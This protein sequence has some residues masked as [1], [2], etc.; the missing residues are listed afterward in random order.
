MPTQ[1][2]SNLSITTRL[3]TL[4]APPSYT[5]EEGVWRNRLL[6]LAIW[7]LLPTSTIAG[8]VIASV[9]TR[10]TG[11]LVGASVS[12]T[13]AGVLILLMRKGQKRRASYIL[14]Y[15][16]CVVF[17]A[18]FYFFG[19]LQGPFLSYV[20]IIMIGSF[21]L[22]WQAAIFT[23]VIGVVSGLGMMLAEING[24]LPATQL[25]RTVVGDWIVA[26]LVFAV[27]AFVMGI[28]TRDVDHSL[29]SA[30]KELRER[31]QM[32]GEL[33][34]LAAIVKQTTETVII[35]DPDGEIVYVNPQ[36]ET[37][38]G[39]RAEEVIGKNPRL[40]KSGSH[41]AEFYSG[42]WDTIQAGK[43]WRGVIKN[44]R[45][46]GSLY[47]K[48]SDIFPVRGPDDELIYYADVS[49]D[50]TDRLRNNLALEQRV[51]ELTVL[52]AVA[53]AN[54]EAVNEDGLIE[55]ITQ[56][57]GETLYSDHFGVLLLV[58]NDSGLQP[59]PSYHGISE[60]D[61]STV[62][63]LDAGVAGHVAR[64]GQP[65]RVSDVTKEPLYFNVTPNMRSELCIP[66]RSG[67]RTIG[68][69]NAESAE[70][71]AFTEFDEQLMTTLAD[72]MATGIEKVRLFEESQQQTRELIAMN[73]LALET[74]SVLDMNLLLYRLYEEIQELIPAE[75]FLVTLFNETKQE[76][77]IAL[78]MEDNEIVEEMID[79]VLPMANGGLSG[80]V[81]KTQEPLLI[82]D[83]LHDTVPVPPKHGSRPARSWLGVP[84]AARGSIIGAISLQSF[85]PNFFSRNQ[86]RLVESLAAQVAIALDNAKLFEAEQ[87]RRRELQAMATI[88][89]ALREAE[90]RGEMLP[91][92]LQKVE[93]FSQA[94]GT[95]LWMLAPRNQ[96][97]LCELSSG[98]W[99]SCSGLRREVDKEFKTA[100]D[101]GVPLQ[102]ERNSQDWPEGQAELF[103]GLDAI[104]HIPLISEDQHLGILCVG[105][106][107]PFEEGEIRV[108]S[109]IA[110]ISSNAI[111][112]ASLHD[113]TEQ[114]LER[115]HSLRRIDQAINASLDLGLTLRILVEQVTSQL[116]T[117][118][119]SVSLLIPRTQT[120]ETAARLGFQSESQLSSHIRLGSGLA[121][122]AALER[123][124]I[125]VGNFEASMTDPE[126]ARMMENEGFQA[127]FAVPLLA[128]GRVKGVLEVFNRKPLD[129]DLEWI[130]F[131]ETLAG[132]AAIAVE[133]ANLVQNL[134]RTNLE[135]TLAYDTT[136]EGWAH[137]LELRDHETQGHAQRVTEL[138]LQLAREL[139][140]T[141]EAL[142]NIRR[143]TLLHD[144]GKMGIP[145]QILLKPGPLNDEE[146]EV[147]RQHPVYAYEMLSQIPYLRPA[148]DIPYCHHERWDGTGY[149]R[150]LIGKSIPIAARIFA[151]V[152]VWDAL[153]SDRP[154]RK[155]WP[156]EKA[157][158][159]IKK[160]AGAHFDPLVVDKFLTLVADGGFPTANLSIPAQQ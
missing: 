48:E 89:S 69:I 153:C 36:F 146:W 125:Q 111:R 2:P 143:G 7:T 29:Q 137:A 25:P 21:I 70:R 80:H 148:L 110:N 121:G 157:L 152:D 39:Y 108:L 103:A 22:G 114:R 129:P 61:K 27:A 54:A 82:H 26:T 24:V 122:Q 77:H 116:D 131:L 67:N 14:G 50:V 32:Q 62:Y 126:H 135:L 49:R 106:S 30:R 87:D 86:L 42:L 65:R 90:N 8:L 138:T 147:M 109:A 160:E 95:A 133:N 15:G 52:H 34:S 105:R 1:P 151:V 101:Q 73:A 85:T 150:G 139:D 45:K 149:P 43:N 99:H 4:F 33:A 9:S 104:L 97:F 18:Y 37:D 66:I 41:T 68:L 56:I 112:R 92:I 91:M 53:K 120:L 17:V 59:H 128:K 20:M 107:R 58:D 63:P 142:V 74:T 159:H 84:L 94:E 3:K 13:L 23:G 102:V 88:S 127:Y 40:L 124:T 47:D 44:R 12:I 38:T 19:G 134:E 155:A 31:I 156:I 72:Q 57:I 64:T 117:H 78:A 79:L 83:L 93:Q 132:Q 136:L 11:G 144:I 118:A 10:P 55:K 96:E 35:T 60:A 154:Y 123:K 76:I 46:D 81:V 5:D 75:T 115:L 100:L 98:A 113:E 141:D 119:A 145:D 71:N 140:L 6:N 51:K 16:I 130:D 158:A 28:V